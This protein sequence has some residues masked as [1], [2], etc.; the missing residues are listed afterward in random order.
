MKKSN[1]YGY[2]IYAKNINELE[3][4]WKECQ[5]YEKEFGDLKMN[6]WE[7]EC[8][9]VMNTII[10]AQNYRRVLLLNF[11]LLLHLL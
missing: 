8:Y 6:K 1:W 3:K 4:N 11:L 2:L 9:Q 5:L 10:K 7:D